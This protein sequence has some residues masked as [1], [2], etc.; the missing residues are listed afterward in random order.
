MRPESYSRVC[1]DANLI[2][3]HFMG[4][5]GADDPVE[6]MIRRSDAGEI[7]LYASTLIL[8]EA[9]GQKPGGLIDEAQ[10]E[11]VTAFL[12]SPTIT[13]VD[14]DYF[15]A[16]EARQIRLREREFKKQWDAIHLATAATSQSEVFFT[17]DEDL[18]LDRE[19]S[20]VWMSKP[21]EGFTPDHPMF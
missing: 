8:V 5:F 17:M 7:E 18:K 19:V 2:I 9:L 12:E 11:R 6:W 20:G 14:M 10:E 16:V 4:E 15:V 13:L 1:I 21:Y 3:K